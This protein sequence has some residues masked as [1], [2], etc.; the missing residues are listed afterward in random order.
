MNPVPSEKPARLI[1]AIT[2]ASGAIIGIRLL[3]HARILPVE[4]HLVISEAG[5]LTIKQETDWQAD[6]VLALADVHYE[7]QNIS[8]SIA[9]GSFQ[10]HGMVIVPCSIKSLS[11][12]ANAFS[13]DLIS[14]AADVTLKEGR[15]L[16]LAVR[17]TPFNNSHLRLMSLAVESGAII[18]PLIPSFY[19]HPKTV[20]ELVDQLAMRILSRMG[21]TTPGLTEWN[22]LGT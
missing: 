12:V 11:A 21:F 5:L 19:N 10:T 9:S 6:D 8:A 17:E 20:G 4:I 13:H 22:G 18:F 1:V 3:E 16:V 7:P 14:R 15:P 2:G